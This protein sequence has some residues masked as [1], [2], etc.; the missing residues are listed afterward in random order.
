MVL[1]KIGVRNQAVDAVRGATM[2]SNNKP[3]LIVRLGDIRD[4]L[5][6]FGLREFEIDEI[7][8]MI[9][10]LSNKTPCSHERPYRKTIC[11]GVKGH[12]GS[13]HAMIYWEEE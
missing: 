2:K 7:Q 8:N 9:I 6:N 11:Q 4:R 13:H 12:K 10:Q 1:L 5:D 3:L